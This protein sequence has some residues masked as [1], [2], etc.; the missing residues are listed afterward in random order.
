MYEPR[1]MKTIHHFNYNPVMV[2]MNFFFYENDTR[3]HQ[4]YHFYVSKPDSEIW[5]PCPYLA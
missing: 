1:N 3:V 5:I 2:L 4:E